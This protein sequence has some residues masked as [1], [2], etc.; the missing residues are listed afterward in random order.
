MSNSKANRASLNRS[1]R[2]LTGEY[3]MRS[4]P[5]H[6]KPI[7]RMES[8]AY[9]A[10]LKHIRV[11]TKLGSKI[12][13]A[14]GFEGDRMSRIARN[15]IEQYET[16][17]LRNKHAKLESVHLIEYIKTRKD[18]TP[19]HSVEI[20]TWYLK[21][22]NERISRMRKWHGVVGTPTKIWLRTE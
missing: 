15:V 4:I 16:Y 14:L 8:S 21:H 11:S 20:A 6:D 17:R 19:I 5:P 12:S 9:K 18:I 3:T 7:D 2:L 13:I 10:T 1:L 22:G